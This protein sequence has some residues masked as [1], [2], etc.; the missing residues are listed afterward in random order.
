MKALGI[1]IKQFWNDPNF[2]FPKGEVEWDSDDFDI[3]F[4]ELNDNEKYNLAELGWYNYINY[5]SYISFESAFKLWKRQ[6]TTTTI[7]I[8]VEKSK[9]DEVM[10]LLKNKFGKIKVI[11]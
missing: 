2:E 10:S 4:D 1:E 5:D 8:E 6:Q 11:K 3:D 9:I 7:L